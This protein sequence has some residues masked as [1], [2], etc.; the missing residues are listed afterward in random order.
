MSKTLLEANFQTINLKT[1][2]NRLTNVNTE[3]DQ[4]KAD[5]SAVT[6]TSL[7]NSISECGEV[8][9][10]RLDANNKLSPEARQESYKIESV[11]FKEFFNKFWDTECANQLFL[12]GDNLRK[13]LK[14]IGFNAKTNPILAFILQNG[15]QERLLKT[16][17]LNVD[18]FKVIS[19]AFVS[20]KIA[21][22][23][24]M[25]E[26]SYNIIYCADLYRKPLKEME[27]Y[28]KLQHEIL[29]ASGSSLKYS[30]AII[31]KNRMVFYAVPG[32]NEPDI[33]KR[34]AALEKVPV[35]KLPKAENATLNSIASAKAIDE[36]LGGVSHETKVT[37]LASSDITA[38][39]DKLDTNPKRLAA[40]MSL[41][42]TTN[43]DEAKAAAVSKKFKG[44]TTDELRQATIEIAPIM[45]KGQLSKSSTSVLINA[46]LSKA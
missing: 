42:I 41:S 2:Y 27:E 22:G 1:I 35:D 4:P 24:F 36:K 8:L 28:I 13:I 45:P 12:I 21:H 17:L 23:Q 31:N 18:T 16:K 11:F 5:T 44:I 34:V 25:Q 20:K 38:L 37:T 30:A 32:I 14:G 6:D 39:A 9:K 46:L 33:N 43:N 15:V 19:S 10:A 29:V 40:I 7:P 3:E 26:R